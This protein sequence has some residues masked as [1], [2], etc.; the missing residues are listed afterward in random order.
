MSIVTIYRGEIMRLVWLIGLLLVMTVRVNAQDVDQYRLRMPSASEYIDRIATIAGQQAAMP[1]WDK[2]WFY[3]NFTTVLFWRFPDLNDV[4]Y[5]NII[6]A[7]DA[8]EIGQDGDFWW[9]GQWVEAIFAAWLEQTQPDLSQQ[10]VLR[11]DNFEIGVATHDFNADGQNEYIL[12]VIKGQ[13][14]DRLSCRYEAE[15]VNYFV[16]ESNS[17]GYRIVETPLFWEGY[18]TDSSGSNFGEG[19]QVT[20]KV[21]DINADGLLEWLVMVGGESF[22]G[23]GMGYENVGQLFIL[24]WR[25]GRLVDLAALGSEIPYPNSVTHYSEDSYGCDNAVPRDVTWEFV[26]IDADAAQEILQRQVYRD[27]WHCIARETRVLDWN[28]EQDRYVE[29]DSSRDFPEDTQNCARR[30]AE[31]V[32]WVGDYDAAL[33]HYER[34]LTLPA[35]VDPDETNPAYDEYIR[36]QLRDYRV[37]YDQYHRARMALAYQLTHRPAQ[38]RPILEVLSG[39]DIPFA[40]VRQFVDAL[41][42]AP[43]TPLGACLAA[44]NSFTQPDYSLSEYY[45]GVTLERT[46]EVYAEYSPSRIGCDAPPMLEAALLATDLSTTRQ[47]PEIMASLG[48]ATG[49]VLQADLNGD[50]Q[51]EW[52]VWTAIPMNPFFFAVNDADRY[53]VST[54]PV[55]PFRRATQRHLWT[56]PDEEGVAIAY[57]MSQFSVAYPAPWS[58]NYDPICG[59]GGSGDCL[60]DGLHYLTLWRM[61]GLY[62]TSLVHSLEVCRTDFATLFPDDEGSREIDG[63]EFISYDVDPARSTPVRY[64]WDTANSTFVEVHDATQLPPSP[65]FTSTP[66]PEY[67]SICSALDAGDYFAALSLHDARVDLN[68]DYYRS[69]PDAVYEYR[70]QRAFLLERVARLDEALAEYIAIYEADAASPWG[71]MAALHIEGVGGD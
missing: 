3:G 55:D 21:E 7:Y 16:V 59:L 41:L 23:P 69:N 47:P 11:F 60:P 51:D 29:I 25:D 70:Y 54:P 19:G 10:A 64:V 28:A 12:D 45:F 62:L 65:T 2:R 30:A 14:T 42:A 34:A 43:E 53:V 40:P 8:M 37:T 15:Y 6:A 33:A 71:Q 36:N 24:G 22:G 46:Y 20:V 58:C 48:A 26:N 31:E 52:L 63:G 67:D 57:V 5:Q 13:A 44:Y 56:L 68:S 17:E 49:E 18:G 1:E 27:N 32:M 9:R 50:D 35:Y 66:E 38:A 61:E 39:E 4:D